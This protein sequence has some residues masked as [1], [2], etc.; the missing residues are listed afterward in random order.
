MWLVHRNAVLTTVNTD[1]IF[2]QLQLLLDNISLFT[3][4]AL[5]GGEMQRV[6]LVSA[7][8]KLDYFG[9]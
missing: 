6:F 1:T 8:F 3:Q 5:A 2:E 4:P 7:G 9:T